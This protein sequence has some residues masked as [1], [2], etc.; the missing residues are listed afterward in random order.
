LT[1]PQIQMAKTWFKF[2]N[3]ADDDKIKLSIN[4]EIGG[5]G[6]NSKDFKAALAQQDPEKKIELHI[7]SGGGD[8]FEGNEIH[9]ALKA[10]PG[11]VET[12]AG[13]IC[14]SIATVIHQ[15]GSKRTMAKN[16]IYMVHNPY[17]VAQGDADA[18]KKMAD[19]L[20]TIKESIVSTYADSTKQP[21]EDLSKLM[22]EETW[23]TADEAKE[24]GFIDEVDDEEADDED[25]ILNRLTLNK[26]KNAA[27]ALV[28]VSRSKKVGEAK[29]SAEKTSQQPNQ[30]TTMNEI[31]E[32]YKNGSLR[33][34]NALDLNS[35]ADV[36][37]VKNAAAE[38][39]KTKL[40]KDKEK[41]DIV[42]LL[43][44][45]ENKD[46]SA[47]LEKSIAT[48]ESVDAFRAS[49]LSG[50]AEFVAI[51]DE[52][53]KSVELVEPLDSFKGSAGYNFVTSDKFK[54]QFSAF[55]QGAMKNLSVEVPAF[56]N[57]ATVGTTATYEQRPG[58]VE[59]GVRPLTVE[60]V[61]GSAST[62]ANAIIYLQENG[63]AGINDTATSEVG[64]LQAAGVSYTQ[65]TA[66]VE[67]VGDFIP[68][69][70]QLI[71]DLPAIASLIN[72]RLPYY[73]DRA[74]ENRLL[75]AA[76]SGTGITGIL[77][78]AG[79]QTVSQSAYTAPTNASP[80]AA[81]LDLALHM[82]T[83]VRY[84]GL[85]ANGAQGGFEPDAYLIHPLDWEAISLA[86]DSIGQFYRV[87]P[88]SAIDGVN[89]LWGKKVVVTPAVA[90]GSPVCG[91]FKIGAT[92]FNRQ[93]M[94]IELTNSDGTNFQNRITT[95]RAA[96]RLALTVDRPASFVQ[97]TGVNPQS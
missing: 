64:Q 92:V 30:K 91:A 38:I 24:N 26:Y 18:F 19:V 25:D 22:D 13:A 42:A 46:Y 37:A 33:I 39:Y 93:G 57:T 82:Q 78:S 12:H 80:V 85:A 51:K 16:G 40:A 32:A 5:Y 2:L 65:L 21:K 52:A 73:V 60:Q 31:L 23:M 14:A 53:K 97:A 61:L 59:L 81:F 45:R 35:P 87:N 58:V 89:T 1:L 28:K 86:K 69:S 43:K 67:A 62:D 47:A 94:L 3:K 77:H 79:I 7:N 76:A 96:R 72:T 83:L 90:Q 74:V 55:K 8:V 63:Y 56:K 88:F 11:G 20:D 29:A 4:D 44:T 36:E 75:N 41:K 48:D 6:V 95:I 34:F 17:T 50:T 71:A 70:D 27:V 15:A 9:N 68:V 10:H 84:Q 54:A 66:T 49:I